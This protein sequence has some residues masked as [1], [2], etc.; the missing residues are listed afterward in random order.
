LEG[1][2]SS[3]KEESIEERQQSDERRMQTIDVVL[4]IML[5][6]YDTA[7]IVSNREARCT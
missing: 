4:A 6:G 3:A 7:C 1:V 5:S 2:T